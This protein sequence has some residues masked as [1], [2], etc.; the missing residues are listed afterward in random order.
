[1]RCRILLRWLYFSFPR[2]TNLDG[3]WWRVEELCWIMVFVELW[4]VGF[5]GKVDKELWN[6]L[7]REE[8]RSNH[9]IRIGV[10]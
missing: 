8:C 9:I 1:M 10:G 2:C 4:C 5:R 3:G 7:V 6:C